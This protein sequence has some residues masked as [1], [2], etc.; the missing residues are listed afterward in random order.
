MDTIMA[1][2]A[3]PPHLYYRPPYRDPQTGALRKRGVWVIVDG[4]SLSVTGCGLEDREGAEMAFQEYLADKH[5]PRRAKDQQVSQV[6]ITDVIAVYLRDKVGDQKRP[7]KAAQRFTQ[8]LEWWAGKT[9]DEVNGR[10]CRDYVAHRCSQPWKSARPADTGNAPRMVTAAGARRELEDLR[11]AINYHAAEGY[12]R[13]IVKVTLPPRSPARTRYLRRGEL[14]QLVWRAW[15]LREQM[16]VGRG[17]R[18][19]LPVLSTKRP[20]RHIARFLLV[21]A[22]TGTRAAAIC[23]AAFEPTPGCGWVDLETGLFHRK[24]LEV[25]ETNKRQPTILLPRRL[26]LHLRRWKRLNPA[27]RFVVEFHGKPIV[28][29]NNGF[30]VLVAAVGLGPEVTPH[31]LRHTA[32]TWLAQRGASAYEAAHFLGMSQATYERVYMHHHPG[33]RM[34]GFKDVPIWEIFDPRYHPT[35]IIVDPYVEAAA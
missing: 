32:A 12:H 34:P 16:T 26:L 17:P 13:E 8:L 18:R 14:A 30:G 11:A 27:Q 21:G 23:G 33:L 9:L 5:E 6:L 29:I 2:S 25:A 1:R 31:V 15:H 7:E 24:G 10:S 3:D 20:A 4:R 28:E 22:Y 35:E 19:G